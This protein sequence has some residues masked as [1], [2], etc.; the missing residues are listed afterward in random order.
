MARIFISHSSK[1]VEP[2]ARM[3][4]W[5]LAQ[6]FD[7]AFLDFDKHAGIPPGADWERRLYREIERAEA[8]I[9]ILTANWFASKWCFAEYTYGRALG[10]TIFPLLESPEGN[11][12]VAPD[13]QHL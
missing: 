4:Q 11:A 3:L 2:A 1:D 7:G 6:G 13:I 5:L 10:K 12:Y 9:L 8:I